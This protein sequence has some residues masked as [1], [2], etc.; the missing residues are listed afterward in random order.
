MGQYAWPQTVSFQATARDGNH[1][2]VVM[3]PD[4][5]RPGYVS[6]INSFQLST[7]SRS[8]EETIWDDQMGYWDNSQGHWTEASWA[9]GYKF[10]SP[11]DGREWDSLQAYF[12]AYTNLTDVDGQPIEIPDPIIIDAPVY[13]PRLWVPEPIWV[14]QPGYRQVMVQ[15]EFLRIEILHAELSVQQDPDL[16]N[17]DQISELYEEDSD[18][19]IFLIDQITTESSFAIDWYTGIFADPRVSFTVE[20]TPRALD[21]LSN[22]E[23]ESHTFALDISIMPPSGND[24]SPAYVAGNKM[25]QELR[26]TYRLQD[27]T[28]VESSIKSSVGSTRVPVGNLI[29]LATIS[30]IDPLLAPA[31]AKALLFTLPTSYP[32]FTY[33][34]QF[35]GSGAHFENF[36][37]NDPIGSSNPGEAAIAFSG[38]IYSPVNALQLVSDSA[39]DW[40]YLIK[41]KISG[42]H[43]EGVV[44]YAHDK[45]PSYLLQFDQ[46]VIEYTPQETLWQLDGGTYGQHTETAPFSFSW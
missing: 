9:A 24:P 38:H 23:L 25:H 45:Y 43:V 12:E 13:C 40:N 15:R 16:V 22:S 19:N 42:R 14:R 1:F 4:N 29:G 32:Q 28:F 20:Q 44:N 34:E 26:F 30:V 17:L 11:I 10:R 37:P 3:T 35:Q 27:Q 41:F 33:W 36:L 8:T 46:R 7:V 21:P 31:L 5:T 2:E 18:G 6:G 39:I